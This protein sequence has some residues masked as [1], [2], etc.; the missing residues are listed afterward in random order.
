[1]VL[2]LDVVAGKAAPPI[3]SPVSKAFLP[4]LLHPFFTKEEHAYEH[5]A[6]VVHDS[7]TIEGGMHGLMT[8]AR[9]TKQQE[10]IF[11]LKKILEVVLAHTRTALTILK[12]KQSELRYCL[13][14]ALFYQLLSC[15][16]QGTN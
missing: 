1:M 2:W 10:D 3:I 14:S 12:S 4:C 6:Q 13:T 8:A 5:F 16:V 9:I 11:S 15:P 7:L